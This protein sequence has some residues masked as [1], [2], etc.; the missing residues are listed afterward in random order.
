[1]KKKVKP[2]GGNGAFDL[3]APGFNATGFSGTF[4]FDNSAL[5]PGER[6]EKVPGAYWLQSQAAGF[7]D[8][9]L[10]N[11]QLSFDIAAGAIA[12][13]KVGGL[14]I[15]FAEPVTLGST[16]VDLSPERGSGGWLNAGGPWQA[17]ANGASMLTLAGKVGVTPATEATR[18]EAVVVEGA[19][20]EVVLP[21]SHVAL[22]IDA[23]D[24]AYPTP[25]CSPTYVR[26]GAAPSYTATALVRRPDGSPNA[27]FVVPQGSRAPVAI[28]AYGIEVAQA[29]VSGQT[30]TFTLNRL[31]IDDVEVMQAGGG[32]Q[33][34]KGTVTVSRKNADGSYTNLN[35][36]FPTHSGIDI[37]DGNYR[38]T[39]R[40]QS[41]SGVVTSTEEV[42]FP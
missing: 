22:E 41:P 39:S 4:V 8:G 28:N 25:T 20:K 37:P 35:C 23:Y 19:L 38:V 6:S 5:K 29:T 40:A 12:K 36:T 9:Q 7:G 2:K 1:V 16:R 3:V 15:R 30:H 13:H 32:S 42:T 34:V 18:S 11:Q 24:P 14:R 17:A 21:T 31:E 27:S 33:L 10:M 26:A